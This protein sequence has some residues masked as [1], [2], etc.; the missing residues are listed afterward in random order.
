MPIK[1]FAISLP[2]A[3]HL[4]AAN[5]NIYVL[6]FGVSREWTHEADTM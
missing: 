1:D 3:H 2:R 6:I 4:C 5:R